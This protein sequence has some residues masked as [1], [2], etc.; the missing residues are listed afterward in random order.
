MWHTVKD[1]FRCEGQ[2]FVYRFL[3]AQYVL[4]MYCVLVKVFLHDI[5]R[6]PVE[7]TSTTEATEPNRGN[8]VDNSLYS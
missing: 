7:V 1:I 3:A 5:Q 6:L 4:I 8:N 2:H